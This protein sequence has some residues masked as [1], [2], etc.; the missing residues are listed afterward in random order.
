MKSRPQSPLDHHLWSSPVSITFGLLLLYFLGDI[1]FILEAVDL[2]HILCPWQ[3]ATADECV[4][5]SELRL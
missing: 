5:V 3:Q 1:T 4:K 2:V